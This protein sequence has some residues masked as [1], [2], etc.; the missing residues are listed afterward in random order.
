M[1]RWFLGNVFQRWG[2]PGL[3]CGLMVLFVGAIWLVTTLAW[4]ATG[5]FLV[6][7]GLAGLGYL[8]LLIFFVRWLRARRQPEHLLMFGRRR[9]PE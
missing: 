8:L 7:G 4:L 2:I 5:V 9:W 3:I 1:I 6:I